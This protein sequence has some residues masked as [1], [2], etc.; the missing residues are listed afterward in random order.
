MSRKENKVL[1]V[2]LTE[3]EWIEIKEVMRMLKKQ[4]LS[5]LIQ[6]Q[7]FQLKEKHCKSYTDITRSSSKIVH[8]R[9]SVTNNVYSAI[10][11]L[12]L[13]LKM[14]P[15]YIITHLIIRPLLKNL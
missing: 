4:N 9:P 5:S 13:I 6:R 15:N 14:E 2:K 7:V 11:Q 12:S 8:K 10:Q 3:E 1:S